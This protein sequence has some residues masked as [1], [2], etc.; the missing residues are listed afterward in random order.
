MAMV[1]LLS[2]CHSFA[3][4][5]GSKCGGWGGVT[6]MLWRPKPTVRAVINCR[7]WE[8]TSCWA[9]DT[10]PCGGEG[11]EGGREG[12]STTHTLVPH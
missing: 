7:Y 9:E 12:S 5:G 4:G 2:H 1:K 3:G 10:S 11:R 6:R 8:W